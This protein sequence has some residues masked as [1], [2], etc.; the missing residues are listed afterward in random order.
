MRT[1][2]CLADPSPSTPPR[3][4]HREN[5]PGNVT[6]HVACEEEESVC[7]ILRLTDPPEG[8]RADDGLERFLGDGRRHIRR[9]DTGCVCMG[10]R[11]PATIGAVVLTTS[12]PRGLSPAT[13]YALL[14]SGV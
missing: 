10:L 5:R 6:R 2:R 4:V 8:D 7:D 9:D 11:R 14:H 1:T 3:P 13:P 12:I